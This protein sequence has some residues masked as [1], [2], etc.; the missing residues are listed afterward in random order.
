[1]VEGR[2]SI[3]HVLWSHVRCVQLGAGCGLIGRMVRGVWVFREYASGHGERFGVAEDS[4]EERLD[5]EI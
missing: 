5:G 3:L 2:S 4:I 1:M